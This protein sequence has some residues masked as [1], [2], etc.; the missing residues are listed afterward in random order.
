MT[1]EKLVRPEIRALK[2][3][4]VAPARGMVK[5]DA[6]ENPYPLPPELR[7]R[8]AAQLAGT[9]YRVA[10]LT[11]GDGGTTYVLLG[12]RERRRGLRAVV[13]LSAPSHRIGRSASA[14]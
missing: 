9:E 4:H 1:P 5:L 7:R 2:A 12:E 10:E 13:A 3:Y 11:C 14:R 6:M 8:L